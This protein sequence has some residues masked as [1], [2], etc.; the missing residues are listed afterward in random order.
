[1]KFFIRSFNPVASDGSRLGYYY[2]DYGG[3][4]QLF[5]LQ[6]IDRGGHRRCHFLLLL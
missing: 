4:H 3:E 1:M 6:H 2:P 5:T